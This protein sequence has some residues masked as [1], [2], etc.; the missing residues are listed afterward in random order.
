MLSVLA[1]IAG[2]AVEYAGQ[3]N[4]HPVGLAMILSL[5][6]ATLLVPRKYASIPILLTMCLIPAGQRFIIGGLDFNFV[7][8]IVLF[9]WM[10]LVIRS[11][12]GGFTWR[13][14]DGVLVAWAVSSTIVYSLQW[15]STSAFV[16]RLGFS[17]DALGGYFFLRCLVKTWED[18]VRLAVAM[19][20]CSFIVA[21]FFAVEKATGRNM[22]SVM[23]GVPE[24]TAVRN[25]R[26]RCQGA[27]SHPILAGCFWAA[28]MPMIASLYWAAP[29]WKHL[30][31]GGIVASLAIVFLSSSSTPVMATAA[32]IFGAS[33]FYLRHY[34]GF[35]RLSVVGILFALHWVMN[36]PVW[37][38]IARIDI[39]GGSTGW[40]RY[41]LVDNAI[42]HFDE[43]ALT[44]VRSTAH[45][46]WGLQDVTN[47]YVL[48]GVRGGVWTLALFLATIVLAFVCISKAARR[49]EN[50]RAKIALVWGIGVSLFVHCMSF[51]AVS[52]FGQSTMLWYLTL[53]MAACVADLTAH[54]PVRRRIPRRAASPKKP[55]AVR[56][57]RQFQHA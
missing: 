17:F 35:I 8:V 1:Q 23:G 42:R 57:P 40:H 4:I 3:S 12:I 52:Y 47:Q 49:V 28:A 5:G 38:L 41:N 39:V 36:K 29:K 11:E 54:T 46:G 15:G 53:A 21:G 48:E 26:L 31:V 44:G 20:M 27:F 45:W 19:I 43:W 22:F 9:G 25:G 2:D 18:V 33:M 32:A 51:I 16:N 6:I 50:D 24:V 13:W 56:T 10:R 34:L 30:A 14:I 55:S 7:R 37:H